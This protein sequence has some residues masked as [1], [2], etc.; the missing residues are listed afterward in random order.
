MQN[1]QSVEI[2]SYWLVL[3]SLQPSDFHSPSVSL[4]MR[5]THATFLG[6]FL[7]IDTVQD[8]FCF[9]INE[10]VY[11]FSLSVFYKTSFLTEQYDSSGKAYILGIRDKRPDKFVGR[12]HCFKVHVQIKQNWD[13][14]PSSVRPKV[15]LMLR[16]LLLVGCV[17]ILSLEKQMQQQYHVI[18]LLSHCFPFSPTKSAANYYWLLWGQGFTREIYPNHKLSAVTSNT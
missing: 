2:D 17:E 12:V 5:M 4:S 13:V 1:S 10:V 14:W 16:A 3:K 15:K 6:F 8:L 9:L 7:F 11:G 18:W